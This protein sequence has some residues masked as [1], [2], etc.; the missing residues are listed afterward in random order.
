MIKHRIFKSL[1]DD[2]K[3]EL[4]VAKYLATCA[5]HQFSKARPVGQGLDD[6]DSERL[7]G[8]SFFISSSFYV[9]GMFLHILIAAHKCKLTESLKKGVLTLCTLEMLKRTFEF[10]AKAEDGYQRHIYDPL[11]ADLKYTNHLQF[12]ERLFQQYTMDLDNQI[13]EFLQRQTFDIFNLRVSEKTDNECD[14]YS[15]M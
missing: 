8:D 9:C 10:F 7:L 5:L 3:Q 12:E 13:D 11:V 1:D 15:I 4:R 6:I 14:R 2:T